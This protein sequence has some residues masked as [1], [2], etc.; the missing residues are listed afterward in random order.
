MPYRMFMT[1]QR[2]TMDKTAVCIFPWERPL[3]EEIHGGGAQVVTIDE[4]ASTKGASKI[5][6]IALKNPEAEHAPSLRDQLI[7][8][9]RVARDENPFNNL[10][11][12]FNRL[13]DKY[14]KHP[15]VDMAVAEKVFGS[16]ANFRRMVKDYRGDTPPKV[17]PLYPDTED[18]SDLDDDRAPSEMTRDELKKALTDRG[19]DYAKNAP[20]EKLVDL[21]TEA[22]A[23]PA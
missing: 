9:T 8:M 1:I 4:M 21:L 3:L 16:A 12:E 5:V 17:D 19:I 10:D 18:D 15:T 20:V 6:E 14:G 22:I 13:F 7:A 11:E 23:Q 2:G